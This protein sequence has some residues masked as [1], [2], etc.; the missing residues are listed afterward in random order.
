M[1]FGKE[2]MYFDGIKFV[3][4]EKLK[5]LETTEWIMFISAIVLAAALIVYLVL[6]SKHHEAEPAPAKKEKE[7]ATLI[8]VHG[9]LC[10][11]IAFVLSYIKLF[12]MPLGG[13]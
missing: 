8:L 11:A 7:S 13:S 2:N 5:G 1:I 4:L 10:I 9:A 6:R 3:L 12:S